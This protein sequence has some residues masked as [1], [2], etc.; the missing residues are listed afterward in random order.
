MRG[1]CLRGVI[2]R[3]RRRTPKQERERNSFAIH[4]ERFSVRPD[5]DGSLKVGAVDFGSHRFKTIKGFRLGMF[6]AISPAARDDR[7]VA[8]KVF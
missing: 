3:R 2:E 8:R 4:L 7:N 1:A 6:V 5:V